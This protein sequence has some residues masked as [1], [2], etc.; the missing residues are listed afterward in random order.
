MKAEDTG[1]ITDE[2]R[3]ATVMERWKKEHRFERTIKELSQFDNK[4]PEELKSEFDNSDVD[5]V[6]SWI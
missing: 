2:H 5:N 6:I 3:N 4:R 1:N